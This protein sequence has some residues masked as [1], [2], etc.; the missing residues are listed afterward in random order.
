[1]RIRLRIYD[2]S[3]STDTERTRA[4]GESSRPQAICSGRGLARPT[5]RWPTVSSKDNF[6]FAHQ[7]RREV[8]WM[9]QNTNTLPVH[10]AILEAIRRSVDEREFNLYPRKAGVPGLVE[11]I[12][13]DLG[14]EGFDVLLTNGG[15]EGEYIATRS[16]LGPGNEVLSTDPSF[17]PIHDQVAMSEAKAV[18]VDIYRK[19]YVLTP[20][21]AN[22]SITPA[23]KMLLLIDPNNPLGSSYTRDQVRGLSDVARDRDL[24]LLNDVTYRDFNKGHV[25][26]SAFYP[27]QTLTSYS[28]SKGPGLAGMRIG[29]LVAPPGGTVMKALRRFDTNV[30]GVNVLAQRAALAALQT[31]KEWLP[32]VRKTCE[33]NQAAIRRAVEKVD[34]ASLPVYPSNANMFVVDLSET[35]VN[36]ET[37]EERLLF[38]HLV[39]TRAGSYLSRRHGGKFLRVSFTVPESDAK[40]FASAFPAVME[41]LAK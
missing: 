11:A 12:L 18:E 15:I 37:V 13:E 33:L 21:W 20:E 6:E 31:K 26:A 4:C 30:L 32:E 17:L 41:T 34:G 2:L 40:R 27:E 16:L 25:L 28:F 23:T 24:W 10:P 29:A 19:P 38:D 7:H 9:S 36:P 22:A 39:H 35:G 8:A 5:P 3:A 14:L 1:M